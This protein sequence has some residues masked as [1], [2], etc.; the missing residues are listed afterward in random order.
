MIEEKGMVINSDYHGL[1]RKAGLD[2]FE[3][4][5]QYKGGRRIKAIKERSVTRI[6]IDGIAL[7]LKRHKR[8][9][10]GLKR[11]SDGRAEFENILAFKRN[12]LATLTPVAMGERFPHFFWV[13]SFLIT[14]DFS[15]FA[16]LENLIKK[17][18]DSLIDQK[19]V[20]LRE[21]A[22]F[23]R[24]MHLA[25]FN[26]R[27][28][29]ANHILLNYRNGSD[30]PEIA[31]FDLQRVD[32]RKFLRFRWIIKCLAEINYTLPDKLF[33]EKDRLYLFLSYKVKN[34]LGF[35]D[36]LQFFWIKRKT[37]RIRRHTEK[38]KGSR[39]GSGL[40]LLS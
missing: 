13:E 22:G 19:K 9:F 25:G 14:R 38:R 6:E 24:R 29:N 26:H 20:L 35:W 3:G 1:L 17:P 15:P 30:V 32:K 11:R 12:D 36:R 7:Y 37:A 8:R 27:D 18:P 23:A 39:K 28:L 16:T 5:W 4:V 33:E 21:I 2:S 40:Y 34:K 31:T 10:A